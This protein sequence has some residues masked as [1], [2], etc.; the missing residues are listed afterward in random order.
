[1]T[2]AERQL[3]TK[4]RD[5][6]QAEI[7]LKNASIALEQ[8]KTTYSVS[9]FKV[10]QADVDVAERNLED[11]L[12]ILSRYEL[13]SPGYEYFQKTLVQAQSRL[14][15]AEAKLVAMLSDFDT[16]EVAI[17]KLQLE[18]V[19]GKLEDAQIAIE[20]AQIA[21]EDAQEEVKDTQETLEEAEGYSAEIIAP[22]AGFITM[23]NVDGGDEIKKVTVAIQ[24]ADPTK[25]EAEV[26]ASEMDIFQVKLGGEG[27]VQVDAM[28]SLT[29]PAKVT[30]ISPTA[31]IQQG[32]VNY[33]VKV[34]I[35]SLQAV[36]QERQKTMQK[37]RQETMPGISRGELPE[38]LRQAIEEGSLTQ[39]QIEEIMK[40]RQQGEGRLPG[41][42]PGAQQE[43]LPTMLPEDFQLREGL[44]VTVSILVEERH[45]VLLIAKQVI[46][47]QGNETHVQVL[48]DGVIEE[49]SIQ[50]GISNWQYTEVTDGLSEGE[51]V[52][53]PETT[54]TPTTSQSRGG[55]PLFGGGGRGG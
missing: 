44:T 53:I 31:T 36:T 45:D 27:S 51:K 55:F 48:K 5:S 1:L 20:D 47:R 3:T 6:I 14:N 13:G 18:I 43:H 49:R 30:H 35:Q 34:E 29:L 21:I 16:E 39:E 12:A 46:I 33:T 4:Q 50:T 32:V 22:F 23:V 28:P 38:R 2:T 54:A 42:E 52:I 15:A 41:R 8:T 24:L 11:T 19:Q 25:L 9:D 17:K 26:M 40:Q 7:N 10:T 37:A